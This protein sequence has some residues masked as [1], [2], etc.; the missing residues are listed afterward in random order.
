MNEYKLQRYSTYLVKDECLYDP[1]KFGYIERRENEGGEWVKWEDVE[2][3]LK[4]YLSLNNIVNESELIKNEINK[5]HRREV[6]GY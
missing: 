2:S 5:I 4:A 6:N 1:I 3:L